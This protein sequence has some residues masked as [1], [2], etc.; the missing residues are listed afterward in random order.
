[1][2]MMTALTGREVKEAELTNWKLKNGLEKQNK[3]KAQIPMLSSYKTPHIILIAR[4][5]RE[6]WKI[7][8]LNWNKKLGQRAIIRT[9]PMPNIESSNWLKLQHPK[10]NLIPSY[11]HVIG[12]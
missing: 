4:R 6:P 7:L 8:L 5:P 12:S 2:W 9:C 3:L 10:G 11:M 1:M